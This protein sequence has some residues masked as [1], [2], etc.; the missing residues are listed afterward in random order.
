MNSENIKDHTT[1]KSGGINFYP[2]CYDRIINRVAD[3]LNR[4]ILLLILFVLFSGSCASPR[5]AGRTGI[6]GRFLDSPSI[7]GS[8]VGIALYDQESGEYLYQYNSDKYFVPASNTKLATLYAG[9]KYLGTGIPGIEYLEYNDTLFVRATGDPTFLL[10][11]F[12]G[13]PVLSFL[14]N[15][16]KPLA[17]IEPAWETNALGFGW[18]WNFYLNYYMAERSPFPVYGNV[19][20][21]AQRDMAGLAEDVKV[22]YVMSSPRHPWP[23]E[24]RSG[25]YENMEIA[26]PVSENRYIVYPGFEGERDIYVPFATNGMQASLELLQDTLGMEVIVLPDVSSRE[27]P[28]D[29]HSVAY[30]HGMPWKFQTVFSRPADSLFRPMMLYSD[31][32]FAEQT[33]MMVSHR[34]TGVMN[35]EK[36]IEYLLENDLKDIPG[37]PRWVDGSGLSRYNLFSP[38]SL[39]WLLE[40]M[41]NEFGIE[42]MSRLLPTGGEGTLE[43]FYLTEGG[44]IFAKTGTLGGNAIALSGFVITERGR[45]LL[46][47]VL[48]N[49]HNKDSHEVRHA[50]QD[51]LKEIIYRY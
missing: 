32:F 6:P 2:G 12:P 5:Y 7:S 44:K 31:N 4:F 1:L 10:M 37:K 20:I 48:V 40:K 26:R 22:T 45:T 27:K 29:N 16:E 15:A 13:Q 30:K 19:I 43:N 24:I 38:V 35:E 49:N 9:L 33:L 36:L 41:I 14:Q 8:H 51:F 25:N 46:F 21:W 47:S 34:L 28:A 42:R 3:R 39:V 23:V 50:V 18:P 11:D 17:F